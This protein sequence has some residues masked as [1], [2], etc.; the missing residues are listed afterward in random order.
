[1]HRE[2][3]FALIFSLK[4]YAAPGRSIKILTADI[5]L[6]GAITQFDH[7]RAV[8]PLAIYMAILN[9]LK[10]VVFPSKRRILAWLHGA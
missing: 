8:S 7:S 4:K 6:G 2:V 3:S 10:G 5:N 1:V 9:R